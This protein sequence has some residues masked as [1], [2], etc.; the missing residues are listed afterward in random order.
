MHSDGEVTLDL[1]FELKSLSGTTLNQIPVISNETID[2][3]IRAKDGQTSVLAGIIESTAMRA[4]S[5]TPGAELLGPLGLAA[6]AQNNQNQN[7][8]L[9]I[10]LTPRL[11]RPGP[12]TGKPIYA[13]RAPV[14][15]GFA[16]ALARPIP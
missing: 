3:T 7:T 6:S 11:I 14:E 8:E 13:G 10:L 1:H 12:E 2:Q 15:S 9:L 5:G 16:P 4:I